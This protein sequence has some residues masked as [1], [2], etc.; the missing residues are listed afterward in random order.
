MVTSDGYL[1]FR[2]MRS[3]GSSVQAEQRQDGQDH[4]HHADDVKNAVHGGR[5]LLRIVAG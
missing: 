2:G 4:D 5:R 3:G 1:R